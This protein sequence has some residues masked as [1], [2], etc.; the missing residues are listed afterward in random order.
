[1]RPRSGGFGRS[2]YLEKEEGKQSAKKCSGDEAIEVASVMFP[3]RQRVEKR[4]GR[5]PKVVSKHD[6]EG[7]DLE[8]EAWQQVFTGGRKAFANGVER[9]LLYLQGSIHQSKS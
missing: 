1:M 4:A 5:G 6:S 3:L 2:V 8:E 9:C 7:K